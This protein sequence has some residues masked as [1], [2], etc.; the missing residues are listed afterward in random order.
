MHPDPLDWSQ[1]V[2]MSIEGPDGWGTLKAA[3]VCNRIPLAKENLVEN[4]PLAKDHFLIMSPFLQD[5]KEF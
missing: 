2:T 1:S 5:F 4:I 3:P